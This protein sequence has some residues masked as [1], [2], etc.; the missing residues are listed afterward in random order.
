MISIIQ[1]C[2]FKGDNYSINIWLNGCDLVAGRSHSLRVYKKEKH[3][4]VYTAWWVKCELS[5]WSQCPNESQCG[6]GEVGE[7][8]ISL[9][10]TQL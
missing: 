8:K 1:I 10:Y 3:A 6:G 9:S 2:N 7:Q 5:I 4:P